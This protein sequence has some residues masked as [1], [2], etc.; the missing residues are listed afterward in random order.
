[1]SKNFTK[2]IITLFLIQLFTS[3]EHD[4]KINQ[5]YFVINQI[6]KIT[7]SSAIIEGKFWSDY[8]RKDIKSL[9]YTLT[10]LDSYDFSRDSISV[11][12]DKND[13]IVTCNIT[14]LKPNTL[15]Y[16]IPTIKYQNSLNI[17]SWGNAQKQSF[18]TLA[19]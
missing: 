1:M 5:S 19:N 7:N 14:G 15:Y 8:P 17:M 10:E 13:G 6:Y 2:L 18:K 12:S 11:F 16:V 9:G 3:C 4:E